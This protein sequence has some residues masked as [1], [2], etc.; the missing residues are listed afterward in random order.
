MRDPGVRSALAHPSPDLVELGLERPARH[1]GGRLPATLAL[2]LRMIGGKDSITAMP[3]S[4]YD[5]PGRKV[6]L[7][8]GAML[9]LTRKTNQSIM[10]GDEIEVSVLAIMGEK[11]R[12][13]IEAP[14][15]VP[16]FRTRSRRRMRER[17]A[18][19]RRSRSL[20]TRSSVVWSWNAAS[21]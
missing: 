12:I 9:V 20:R 1:S 13:G 3:R 2:P 6:G 14:R 21:N 5:R 7:A 15:S 8:R 17:T 4:L 16:L 11:V 10:I 19:A 18:A